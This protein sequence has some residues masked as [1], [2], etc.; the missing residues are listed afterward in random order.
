MN[1]IVEQVAG[2]LRE[3]ARDR[4][5]VERAAIWASLNWLL[6][7]ASLFV[8]VRA[9]G[10]WANVVGLLVAFGLA[11]VLAVIPITPGGLGV[12]ETTLVAV[13]IGFGVDSAVAGLAVPTYRLAEFWLPIPLG[14]LA[15]LSLRRDQRAGKLSEAGR[16]A[17]AHPSSR[18]DWAEEYGHRPQ[19]AGDGSGGDGSGGDGPGDDAAAKAAPT[20]DER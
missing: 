7:A 13:L 17:Y 19:A 12:V 6:D 8:F 15:Y 5:L 3:I 11:N 20:D 2:R 18:F 4:D 9:F 16:R 10:E 1:E 14:G